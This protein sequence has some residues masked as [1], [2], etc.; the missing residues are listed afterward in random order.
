MKQHEATDSVRI[1][2]EM[3]AKI[4]EIAKSKKQTYSGYME[5][6]LMPIVERDW[7]KLHPDKN[8]QP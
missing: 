3:F 8:E 2:K 7:K 1:N 5:L 6:K 4:K